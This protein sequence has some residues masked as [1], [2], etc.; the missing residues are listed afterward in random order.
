MLYCYFFTGT[1]CLAKRMR[2][3]VFFSGR[4]VSFDGCNQTGNVFDVDS[5]APHAG[6][7][8]VATQ[9]NPALS[10][11]QFLAAVKCLRPSSHKQSLVINT[12]I[13][14]R[15][16]IVVTSTIMFKVRIICLWS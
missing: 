6:R 16:A 10:S 15:V 2:G 4:D 5:S 7:Q 9:V 11:R 12:R 14:T 1:E 8:H 3:G 13:A